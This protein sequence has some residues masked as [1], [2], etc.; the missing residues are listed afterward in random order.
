MST[1]YDF[2]VTDRQ[3]NEVGL[4]TYAGKVLLIVIS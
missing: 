2:K 1:V 4:D 3:G